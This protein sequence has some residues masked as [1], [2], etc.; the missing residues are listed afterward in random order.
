MAGIQ[1]VGAGHARETNF[2]FKINTAGGC[3]AASYFFVSPKTTRRAAACCGV[4]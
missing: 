4:D 2:K 1:F 3:P